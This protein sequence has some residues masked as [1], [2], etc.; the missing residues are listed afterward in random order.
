[1]QKSAHQRIGWCCA[2]PWPPATPRARSSHRALA[3]VRPFRR[4][5][6]HPPHTGPCIPHTHARPRTRT[7]TERHAFTAAHTH[8]HIHA[9]PA[10][11]CSP[12][13]T[14]SPPPPARPAPPRPCSSPRKSGVSW[15]W[16]SL[17]SGARGLHAR[18]VATLAA[19]AA[20]LPACLP[21]CPAILFYTNAA[22][23]PPPGSQLPPSPLSPPIN[24]HA[25][26]PARNLLHHHHQLAHPDIDI[27]TRPPPTSPSPCPSACTAR[28]PPTVVVAP[29]PAKRRH[30]PQAAPRRRWLASNN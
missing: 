24:G 20:C 10:R 19:N 30:P 1:M 3:C 17:L 26:L 22:G 16:R 2:H 4:T 21:A 8:T 23:A 18:A 13:R 27:D 28:Y 5:H 15:A 25:M 11:P 6:A 14:P 7:H 12:T 29:A 9:R